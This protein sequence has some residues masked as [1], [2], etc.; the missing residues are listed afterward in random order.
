MSSELTVLTW[1]WHQPDSP[2][3][4]TVDHVAIWAAMVR[5][6][7]HMPHRIA[8]VTDFDGLPSHVERI[9]P[10]RDFE[11]VRI[12]TWGDDKPQCLRRLAMYAPNAGEIFGGRFACMDLDVVVCDDITPLLDCDDEFRIAKGSSPGRIYNGGLQLLT[13]GRRAKVYQ[14]F[15]PEKAAA[16]GK[17]HLGS[18]QAWLAHCLGPNEATWSEDDG[19]YWRSGMRAENSRIVFFPGGVKPWSLAKL[20]TNEFINEHYRGGRSD[21]C[22][23]LGYGETL[24][25]DVDREVARPFGAVIASPEAA[26]H[27]PGPVL[28][29]ANTDDEALRLARMHGFTDLALC[30][31]MEAA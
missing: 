22:L 26:E 2:N 20:G 30:G 3:P 24:W 28:A 1:L 11:H 4:Y 25:D 18:D 23:L 21:R 8:C 29:V 19:L 12:P 10:P 14:D 6:H 5:R 13:A 27:W 31:M 9:E 15:T 16:A 17:Q 7:L